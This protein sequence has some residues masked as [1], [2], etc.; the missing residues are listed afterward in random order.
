MTRTYFVIALAAFVAAGCGEKKVEPAA[1][2]AAEAPAPSEKA[3]AE[4]APSPDEKAPADERT[5]AAD[6]E[7]APEGCGA[8]GAPL[9]PLG[10]WMED[11]ILDPME[12]KDT[13]KLAKLLHTIE[14]MSPKPEWNE[15]EDGWA[16]IARAGAK[17]AEAGDFKGAKA[18][19]KGCHQKW[20]DAYRED[21]WRYPVPEL[22]E[23]AEAGMPNL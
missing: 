15:G 9:C 5:A 8:E 6:V 23:N 19:C 21:F 4:E 12:A 14:F 3:A 2:Q 10:Q 17:A 18:T 22:P 1:E 20:R 7:L 16:Q 11:H 13:E